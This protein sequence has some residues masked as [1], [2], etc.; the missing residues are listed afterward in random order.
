MVEL[1]SDVVVE[2]VDEAT[3]AVEAKVPEAIPL[4]IEEAPEAALLE[5]PVD[6][7]LEIFMLSYEPVSSPKV[8]EV[9]PV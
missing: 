9:A 3:E 7:S 8:Y 1:D 4:A 2:P 6:P 5:L